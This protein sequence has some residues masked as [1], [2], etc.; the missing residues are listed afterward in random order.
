MH[1]FIQTYFSQAEFPSAPPLTGQS[2]TDITKWYLK[3][4]D[5]RQWWTYE[6][7]STLPQSDLEQYWLGTLSEKNGGFLTPPTTVSEVAERAM[8]FAARVQSTDGFWPGEYGGPMFLIPGL[9]IVWY[10]TGKRE[11]ILST[12]QQIELIRYLRNRAH[13]RGGWGLHIESDPT[14]FG[15]VLNYIALRLLGV[16]STD[17]VIVKALNQL[18][19]LGGVLGIPGW[20]KFWLATL[21]LYQWEGMYPV[22]PELWLLP[23]W[24]PLHPHR[25]W[26]HTR[27]VYLPMSYL[28]ALRRTYRPTG[29]EDV[30]HALRSEL[31]PKNTNF[32][33]IPWTQCRS[34]V[35]STDRHA[36]PSRLGRFVWW[37][38]GIYEHVPIQPLRKYALRKVLGMVYG[39]DDNTGSLDLGP[40]NKVMNLLVVYDAA[41]PNSA[42]F[43]QHCSRVKEFL[44]FVID[45]LRFFNGHKPPIEFL[46]FI[47]LI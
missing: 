32:D 19:L 39:E 16:P 20:G 4:E 35:A 34:Y 15:T 42:R 26:I 8:N 2:A 31:Y 7:H 1:K 43:R 22:P 21:G 47:F 10:I 44:W 36:S 30:V 46:T 6:P 28:Y 12:P 37:L 33:R 23:E 11:D 14:V 40:V 38:A 3:T 17:S 41:G 9:V 18:N 29:P 24:L 13:A 5:G 27:M 25:L 45:L